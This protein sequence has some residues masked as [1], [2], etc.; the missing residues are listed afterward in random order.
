MRMVGW[1]P[2]GR[3][4]SAVV[5]S[6]AFPQKRLV[7]RLSASADAH[8]RLFSLHMLV[9]SRP[10]GY[11][12]ASAPLRRDI[13]ANDQLLITARASNAPGRMYSKTTIVIIAAYASCV[14]SFILIHLYPASIF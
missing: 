7:R 6:Q 8:R 14:C 2:P 12:C 11:L 10:A 3:V 5:F 4:E 1:N 9:S 13:G